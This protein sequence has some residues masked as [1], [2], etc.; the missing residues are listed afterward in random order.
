MTPQAVHFQIDVLK[1]SRV[2]RSEGG[3]LMT[4]VG[5]K[6]TLPRSNGMSAIPPKADIGTQP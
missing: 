6:R 1:P 3:L 2:H 4:A 5:H